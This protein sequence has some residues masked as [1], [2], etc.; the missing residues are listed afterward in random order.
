MVGAPCAGRQRP[1]PAAAVPGCG[2]L[3]DGGR[4]LPGPCLGQS[5]MSHSVTLEPVARKQ[6]TGGRGLCVLIVERT[7]GCHVQ[8]LRSR[9]LSHNQEGPGQSRGAK[10][11]CMCPRLAVTSFLFRVSPND[12]RTHHMKLHSKN[13]PFSESF[14]FFL[15]INANSWFSLRASS[16]KQY[17][18]R[19]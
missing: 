8:C 11:S 9:A 19:P 10:G 13:H 5:L 1:L 14:F 15:S 17:F 12:P 3:E 18:C 16:R 4:R 7:S 6:L 2:P